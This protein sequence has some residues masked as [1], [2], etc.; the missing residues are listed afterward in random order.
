[1][2]KLR[3]LVV[4][5]QQ[6]IPVKLDLSSHK[7][8]KKYLEIKLRNDAIVGALGTGTRRYRVVGQIAIVT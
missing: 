4:S 1:M 7:N 3:D 5:G 6:I 8:N 2:G